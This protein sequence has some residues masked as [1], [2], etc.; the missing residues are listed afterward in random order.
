MVS[1]TD[2]M[3][4]ARFNCKRTC[5]Y[6]AFWLALSFVF[7]LVTT[8]HPAGTPLI[9]NL[10]SQESLKFRFA[11]I[12]WFAAGA[13]ILRQ[14]SI[15]LQLALFGGRAVW[16]YKSRLAFIN[17]YWDLF[18]RQIPLKEI[19]SFELGSMGRRRPVGIVVRL[20]NGS[21]RN[22]PTWLFSEPADRIL[23]RLNSVGPGS[24]EK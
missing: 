17:I 7:F 12:G 15:L 14:T 10:K 13:I 11:L 16:V 6:T 1:D 24:I 21:T 20:N 5:G 19:S 23:H 2:A 18:F 3:V 9:E 4:V 22:I 8:R